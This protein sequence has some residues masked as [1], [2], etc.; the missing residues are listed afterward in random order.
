MTGQMMTLLGAFAAMLA[1]LQAG[2]PPETP[3]YIKLLI[4]A[5]NAG[6]SYYLGQ[7]NRGTLPPPE[8]KVTVTVAE[9]PKPPP[10]IASH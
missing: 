10:T 3:V 7:S 6:L 8:Q 4:G 1:F 9:P 5:V 2:L